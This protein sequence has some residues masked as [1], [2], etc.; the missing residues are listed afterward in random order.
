MGVEYSM[1]YKVKHL[2]SAGK[3]P[4]RHGWPNHAAAASCALKLQ[5][6]S[7]R[8]L[9]DSCFSD[10]A[11]YESALKGILTKELENHDTKA[12]ASPLQVGL[13]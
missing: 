5:E 12:A 4:Q 9:S 1:S 2:P 13:C 7:G 8:I 6:Q 3:P 11:A 10:L